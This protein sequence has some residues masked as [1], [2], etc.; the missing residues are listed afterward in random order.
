MR[1]SHGHAC[2][3]IIIII[4]RIRIVP[5]CADDVSMICS[6]CSQ[7]AVSLWWS[8]TLGIGLPGLGLVKIPLWNLKL[9]A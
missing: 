4:L 9:E 7:F 6:S 5:Y 1:R 3:I 8:L 2:I